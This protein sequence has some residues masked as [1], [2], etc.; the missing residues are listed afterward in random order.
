MCFSH[1]KMK[2][3][4]ISITIP[5]L[6][7][8]D[9]DIL[10]ENVSSRVIAF[11]AKNNYWDTNT[12]ISVDTESNSF[13][14]TFRI[15]KD[16]FVM[17][18]TEVNYTSDG[19][20]TFAI[21]LNGGTNVVKNFGNTFTMHGATIENYSRVENKTHEQFTFQVRNNWKSGNVVV[22]MSNPSYSNT[23]FINY[24]QTLKYTVVTNFT[25]QGQKTPQITAQVS[26]FMDKVNDL[27]KL[28][29]IEINEMNTLAE[30]QLNSVTELVVK[31]NL[32]QS[33]IFSWILN[34][35]Q[36]N[37]SSSQ[38]VSINTSNIFV[39]IASNYTST[40]V[41]RTKAIVNSSQFSDNQSG[42]IV[43]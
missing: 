35:G 39:Y 8:E 38:N 41:F 9:Y 25:S 10:S 13:S 3:F 40:G 37:L 11:N 30:N 4:S 33:Q 21:T 42:V 15:R 2:Y 22:T 14:N 17:V 18:M 36:N 26:S 28:K 20:K 29:P 1:S 23:S 16:Q 6:E 7:V 34:T 32:N 24:N 12:T 31:N 19:N 27:F 43:T 5:G